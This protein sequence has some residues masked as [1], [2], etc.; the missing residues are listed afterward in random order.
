MNRNNKK[1]INIISLKNNLNILLSQSQKIERY[2]L[3]NNSR[4]SDIENDYNIYRNGRKGCRIN[5][6]KCLINSESGKIN[7]RINIEGN[8]IPYKNYSLARS[9][10]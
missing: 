6:P 7:Y 5:N 2:E 4:R 9:N 1:K 10:N 8:A 3:K